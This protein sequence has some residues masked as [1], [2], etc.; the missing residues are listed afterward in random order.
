MSSRT[1]KLLAI[2]ALGIAVAIGAVGLG[3]AVAQAKVLI[4]LPY[5]GSPDAQS[6][7]GNPKAL[8][9]KGV[10]YVK[11]MEGQ[12]VLVPTG[13]CLTYD[14]AGNFNKARGSLEMWIKPQWD[15]RDPQWRY[16][17]RENAPSDDLGAFCL[18]LFKYHSYL[19]F[20]IRDPQDRVVT[21]DTSEWRPGCWY[22]VVA[23]WDMDLG[24]RLYINGKESGRNF[25]WKPTPY[26]KIY[27]GSRGGS[28]SAEAA[29]DEV[30]IYDRML[31]PKEVRQ[32]FLAVMPISSFQANRTILQAGERT[33][34][35]ITF[36]NE[37]FIST[38]IGD[39]HLSVLAQEGSP[40]LPE[41]KFAY[42]L[43]PG[44][45]ARAELIVT[46]P[47]PGL[48]TLRCLWE[49]ATNYR[50]DIDLLA[51]AP[52]RE[53]V[54]TT[55]QLR[56]VDEV[57]CTR[58][59]G[60]DRYCDDGTARVVNSSAG[61]YRE[62]GPKRNS[63]F[64]YRMK[65]AEPGLP[66]LLR[67][68]YPDDKD[69]TFLVDM[70]WPE[71]GTRWEVDTGVITGDKYPLT[72]KFQK[73][74]VVFWPLKQDC[75]VMFTSW[76]DDEPAA[77]ARIQIYRIQEG[78]PATKVNPPLDEPGR[79]LGL[80]WED[81][82]INI[83]L[84]ALD[85][86][87]PQF[88]RT[89][90][91]LMD[92]L[93]YTGQNL[94]IYP[95]SFYRG[96]F[97]P[98]RIEDASLEPR[99]PMHPGDWVE[100]ILR[101]AED[102]DVHFIAA[103]NH[104]SAL[105]S[106]ETVANT[107]LAS[108]IA[109]NDT[110]NL[111]NC[112][113]EVAVD[114]GRGGGPVYN[115][116]HPLTRKHFLALIDEILDRYGDL[117]QFKGIALYLWQE[118]SLWF[119][120]ITYGYG[121][122]NIRLFERETGIHVPIDSKDSRRFQKRYLWLMNNKRQEWIDWRCKKVSEFLLEISRHLSKQR[123]DLQLL[124]TCWLPYGTSNRSL[125]DLGP[126]QAG[127]SAQQMYREAGLDFKYY[128]KVPNI[129]IQK[130]LCPSDFRWRAGHYGRS[131]E[132]FLSDSINFDQ[133]TLEV[134]KA[135]GQNSVFI[136][137]RYFE[138]NVWAREPL[139]GYWWQGRGL[140]ANSVSP[141]GRNFLHYYAHALATWDCV[142][143]ANGGSSIGTMGHDAM[144]QEWAKAYRALPAKPFR[145]VAGDTDPV[146]IRDLAQKGR[147]YFYAVNQEAYP[148]QVALEFASQGKSLQV[149][150]LSDG[151][152]IAAQEGKLSIQLLPYQLRSFS[153]SGGKSRI[154]RARAN[155]PSQAADTFT[156]R[157]AALQE[158]LEQFRDKAQ[159]AQEQFEAIRD[160]LAAKIP[161]GNLIAN[162]GFDEGT[163]GEVPPQWRAN[164]KGPD[165]KPNAYLDDSTAHSGRY[166]FKMD[167]SSGMR[168]GAGSRGEFP[169]LPGSYLT[170]S[171]WMKTDTPGF[172]IRLIIGSPGWHKT[173]KVFA[174]SEWR[175]YDFAI[176]IPGPGDA[177]F[178]PELNMLRV[179]WECDYG[180]K[181]N[182][183]IDDV[184]L[185]A[186]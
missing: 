103:L 92:Y 97:Y 117:P 79:M 78:L 42:H 51:V 1:L 136:Y 53:Q 30:R 25:K 22:H 26:S 169:A 95:V 48:Y 63:R 171:L 91:N 133:P 143:M 5:D 39:L 55:L 177:H 82:S 176:K 142:S 125:A 112:K 64:A 180:M 15:G 76:A 132:V 85:N 35:A 11:G 168:S 14:T 71:T 94:I 58:D 134:F 165:G 160:K 86:T 116:L 123:K 33:K 17:F 146:V 139:P 99:R 144:I 7:Q 18:R 74:E 24:L 107:D 70:D 111:M 59:H 145:Q 153:I 80:M 128:Q 108:I 46:L 96:P 84:G 89:V 43:K 62:A 101:T 34:V 124:L 68:T 155:L 137:N 113:N 183:W 170:L 40:I 172:P 179:W 118:S 9:A 65:V 131:P 174:D 87:V 178:Q 81:A 21:K 166:S 66:H 149:K 141:G 28:N 2:A 162:G 16:L 10:S 38:A 129:Y 156:K 100:D 93:R 120:N 159:K 83:D 98:S 185:V 32:R 72:Q 69:R 158:T 57:D 152:L 73:L 167:S 104:L 130:D 102:Y 105:P 36:N 154:Q 122:Y 45:P 161:Q 164:S 110:C 56:L 138:S 127:K 8:E 173:Q 90:A 77:A 19:R 37:G 31:T 163:V 13:A 147:Y 12:A 109:G 75:S 106:L 181:G 148:V 29:F 135:P 151:K 67:A 44:E 41:K 119:G 23:A 115:P 175:K 140:I 52:P 20:D 50:Q 157:K 182:L 4:Y 114:D 60:P 126:I 184:S 47:N 121:D 88:H 27:L 3:F 49:G 6:A 61:R 150:E 186:D 54:P